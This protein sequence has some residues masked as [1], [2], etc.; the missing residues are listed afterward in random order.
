MLRVVTS[1]FLLFASQSFALDLSKMSEK[2]RALFQKEIRIYILENPEIIMEAVEVL[3]QK[4]QQAAIQ[5]RLRIG[6]K[7]QKSHI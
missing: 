6:Q 7:L 2:E 3:R 1:F 5:F 4:E